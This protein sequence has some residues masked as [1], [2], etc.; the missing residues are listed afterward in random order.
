LYLLVWLVSV[1]RYGVV[2]E[3]VPSTVVE[4]VVVTPRR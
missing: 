3:E 1:L 2:V 4:L